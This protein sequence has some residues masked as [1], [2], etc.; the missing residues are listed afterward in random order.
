MKRFRDTDYYV[1]ENGDVFRKYKNKIRLKKPQMVRK[2]KNGKPI[3]DKY[4][5]MYLYQK[6][7]GT[8]FLTHRLVAEV[9]LPNPNNL[10]EVDHLD[11][12]RFNNH[13][14]NLEWVSG[15]EN[16]K[17]AVDSGLMKKNNPLSDIPTL[18]SIPPGVRTIQ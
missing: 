4:F 2:Y 16:R 9:Y 6:S 11:N 18:S 3:K 1:C 13:Y 10:P 8:F 12:N 5:G 14:T 17:R 7:K 15:D